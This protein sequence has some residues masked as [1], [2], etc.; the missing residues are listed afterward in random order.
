MNERVLTRI[1]RSAIGNVGERVYATLREAIVT[2]ALEPGQRLSE[3]ELSVPLGVSRTP[4]RAA[5]A[6]LREDRLVAIVPQLGTFVTLISPRAV[7]DAAFVREA[8]ECSAIR[9]TT[10]RIDRAGL[11]ELHANIVA[12]VKVVEERD[13]EAFDLL[14]EALHRTICEQSGHKIAWSV[15][16]RANGHLDR[17][18]RL[19]LPDSGYMAAMLGEHR[20]MIGAIA[21]GDPAQA[22]RELRQHLRTVL[23][24]LDQIRSAHPEY[25]EQE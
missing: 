20:T 17:I 19:S 12:Q 7:G 23:S 25:F 2:A 4:I 22:E 16:R 18:R 21:D 11:E 8:L 3:N 5:L 6:R 10:E 15:S 24:S 1:A 14:D 13:D 9:L